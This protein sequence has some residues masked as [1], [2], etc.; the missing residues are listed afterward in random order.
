[1]T[2]F[3]KYTRTI[4][5]NNASVAEWASIVGKKEGEGPL[6]CDFDYIS[7]DSHFGQ[8]TWELAESHMQSLAVRTLLDKSSLAPADIN[9][10]YAG[11]L[12]N[13]CVGSTF[14]IRDFGIPFIGMFGA[15]S[16]M[17]ESIIQAAMAIDGHH[18][19]NCIALTS[20]HFCSAERQFRTPLEYGGQRPPTAQ[21]TVTGAGA[22]LISSVEQP[23]YIAHV[24]PGKIVD[25]GVTDVNNMGAAMAPSACDTLTAFF[26]DTKTTPSDYDM[27]VTGDLSSVGTEMLKEQ[28]SDIGITL[29]KNYN[30]CGVMIY[31]HDQ[32]VDAGGSGC[33]CSAVVLAGH[34][35]NKMKNRTINNLL[36]IG[37]G[38][39]MSPTSSMQGESIPGISHLVHFSMTKS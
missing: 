32:K 38:A 31:T 20:S 37:T 28:M 5:I 15:C 11:D 18:V 2:D 26:N 1:M 23:P 14:G 39:L 30:D 10:I 7:E 35:L 13:Q 4:K 19:A 12:L 3:T 36:F 17:A 29:G 34:L 24:T 8:K 22:V 21:W 25:L 6:E 33:G 9:L 16:T 27:I